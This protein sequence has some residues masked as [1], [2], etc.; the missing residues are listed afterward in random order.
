MANCEKIWDTLDNPLDRGK[1]YAAS[2]NHT[3]QMAHLNFERQLEFSFSTFC[4][5][6][7]F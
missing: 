5:K 6:R 2:N 3:T 4:I 7:M 1:L